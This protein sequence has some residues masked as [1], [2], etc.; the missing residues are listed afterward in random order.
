MK[1]FLLILLLIGCSKQQPQQQTVGGAL[2]DMPN[3]VPV[4]ISKGFVPVAKDVAIAARGKQDRTPPTVTITSPVANAQVSG[5]VLIS[6]N[7]YDKGGLASYSIAINSVKVAS[8]TFYNWNTTG[9][10]S[11]LYT[12]TA[13]A[14]DLAGN[15]KSTSIT[16]TINTVIV[17]PP[18]NPSTEV[19][20]KMPPVGN[21]GNEGSC[22][23]F[24]V[25]Y[26]A[27]SVDWYYK[28][29]ATSYSYSTN[30]FS[31]EH[32]YNQVKFDVDCLSG[33]AM[34]TALDYIVANGIVTYSSMPYVSGSCDLQPT[35]A[36]LTEAAGYKIAGY[37]KIYTSD[38]A[39]IRQMINSNKAVIISIAGDNSFISAKA[40]FVWRVYSG[41][42]YVAHSVVICGY[43]DTKNAWKIMNSWGTAWADAG[44][45]WIDYDLFPTRT[46]TWCYAIN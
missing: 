38:K 31:P 16:V 2:P 19:S 40:G 39:M 43:D 7:T 6:F 10:P 18:P 24:S 44:Y 30:I 26:A 11:G 37:H 3:N 27:R 14:T 12:I 15:S 36:Q 1:N 35:A 28:T 25:G 42:G 8:L 45:S 23:A 4:L 32:L 33:T 9:L 13:T 41:S 22:V 34:Q 17:E 5:T 29:G 20:L 21:Q 46:G